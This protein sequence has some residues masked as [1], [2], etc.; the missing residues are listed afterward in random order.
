MRRDGV[1]VDSHMEVWDELSLPQKLSVGGFRST[2]AFGVKRRERAA[3]ENTLPPCFHAC[4]WVHKHYL[5]LADL[6]LTSQKCC[7]IIVGFWRLLFPFFVLFF[8]SIESHDSQGFVCVV[9]FIVKADNLRKPVFFPF[10]FPIVS[11]CFSSFLT[12]FLKR[13]VTSLVNTARLRKPVETSLLSWVR[14]LFPMFS[15]TSR[16]CSLISAWS[17]IQH[18]CTQSRCRHRQ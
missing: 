15:S 12:R 9:N 17:E 14:W 18:T 16:Y 6:Y 1:S 2:S 5:N 10:P 8:M 4:M 3:V 7:L 11:K 13:A